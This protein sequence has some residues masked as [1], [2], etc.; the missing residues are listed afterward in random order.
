[1][2]GLRHLRVSP[3]HQ[4]CRVAATKINVRIRR[5]QLLETGGRARL[6]AANKSRIVRSNSSTVSGVNEASPPVGHT[7]HIDWERES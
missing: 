5:I 3:V 6:A 7:T 2:A 1:M 4:H